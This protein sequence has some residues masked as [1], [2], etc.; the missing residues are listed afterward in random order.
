MHHD[1][2]T[3]LAEITKMIH[4]KLDKRSVLEQ[5]VKAISEEIVRCDA[6]GIY[7]PIGPEHYQGYV[8]KPDHFNGITLDKM[9][10]DLNKDRFAAEIVKTK[11]SIYIPDTS[12]DDR[13]DPVPIELFKI[14]SVF[15]IPIYYEKSLY[16]LVFLFD[17]SSPLHLN[18]EELEAIESYITMAAVALRNTEL[19]KHSKKLVEDKQLLLNATSDLSRCTTVK[20]ALETS[21]KYI[22]K[23]LNNPNVGA[24][25]KDIRTQFTLPHKLS[26]ESEW[27]EE[28]W[29]RVHSEAKINFQKD[30]VFLEVMRTK[31]PVL[32]EDAINDPRPN[33]QAIE[34]FG[35]KAMYMLPMISRD[36]V[37]GTLAIVNFDHQKTYTDAEQQL[38]ISIADATAGVV[39]NLIHLEHLEDIIE[40]R[41]SELQEKNEILETMNED[42]RQLSKK[43]ESILNSAGEGIYG[44]DKNGVITFCN[45]TAAT[46]L[47]Y[48]VDDL[49]GKKQDEVVAHFSK[50]ME[51]YQQMSSPIHESLATGE[52]AYSAEEKFA[53]KSGELFDVEYVSTPIRNGS[54]HSGAVVT[55]RNVTE[56]KEMER[57]I[58]TQAYYDVITRLPNRSYMTQKIKTALTT[59]YETDRLG[60]LFLDLDRFKLINDSYGHAVGD[61]VLYEI[62]DRFRTLVS[63][64]ITVSRLGGDEFMVLVED[65]ERIE[66]LDEVAMKLLSCLTEPIRIGNHELFT[67][68]SIGISV[69]PDDAQNE[70]E[71]IRNADTAMYVAK[72]YGSTYHYFT[73]L[74]REKN[75]ERSNLLN[76]L[77]Q[78][79]EKDELEVYYQPKVNYYTKEITGV[80]ALLRWTHPEFGK[81]P[82]DKFIPLAEETG[83]ILKLGNWVLREA[84]HQ[85]KVW[86][87]EGN[88]ITMAVN[89]SI[90][91]IQHPRVVQTVQ[92]ALN[93]AGIDPKYLEIELTEHTL[94]QSHDAAKI[95][96]LKDLGLTIALDDFGTGYSSL[97]YIKDFPIDC[98]KIDRS[99]VDGMTHVP[100]I[101]ALNSTI[102]HLA[103]QLDYEVVAE[104]VETQ[105]QID[106]LMKEGCYCIQ[107]Y[108]FSR[109]VPA[110]ELQELF[111]RGIGG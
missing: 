40:H 99:F 23:A 4:L 76:A 28:D 39:D 52:K 38:A 83:L 81:V 111:D 36:E 19:F 88:L 103:K 86:H 3:R 35:I 62:A 5:V 33:K 90:R 24:H 109:P 51:Q 79:L 16:G 98:I 55:F 41:T 18:K 17:Y 2:Y 48:E 54:S 92:S 14:K 85:L 8:G 71:L 84:I 110:A 30:P 53:G 69:Y 97:K 94:I 22:K 87:V 21:F 57:K 73:R 20:G 10:I 44:L 34:C 11:K 102:I 101:A 106:M 32:I 13:P 49:V 25:L 100:H 56:R 9:V 6:V 50:E 70:E 96:E 37:L 72:E 42:L 12:Q 93:D 58:H 31:Q 91:Q 77:H 1:R 47:D 68:A 65:V 104:G 29:K 108:F 43:N 59:V 60:V 82:P 7:L 67:G 74:L 89:F 107:G 78:A 15:G 45:P 46:M 75:V 80:E 64:R 95:H 66:E 26:P 105:E 61:R 27:D 63:S